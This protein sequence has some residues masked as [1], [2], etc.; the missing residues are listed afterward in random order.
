MYIC[1]LCTSSSTFWDGR[2]LAFEFNKAL[3]AQL[4]AVVSLRVTVL[5]ALEGS[6]D[7]QPDAGIAVVASSQ[8]QKALNFAGFR[9]LWW[10]KPLIRH[11]LINKPEG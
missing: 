11:N 1:V 10:R 8:Q 9:R 7:E 4:Q 2:R 6:R 5:C 3:C